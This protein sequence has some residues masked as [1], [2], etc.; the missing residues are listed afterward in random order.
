[1][2]LVN[3]TFLS[4][5]I[6]DHT[7]SVSSV[8]MKMW[9]Q[10]CI[11]STFSWPTGRMSLIP[12]HKVCVVDLRHVKEP[13][14]AWLRCFVSHMSQPLFLTY[15]SPASVPDGS[16]CWIR[17]IWMHV[18]GLTA[19]HLLLICPNLGYGTIL[20]VAFTHQDC[21]ASSLVWFGFLVYL[22]LYI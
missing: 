11:S 18:L 21:S 7:A 5:C 19:S 12:F 10:P 15:D 9:V 8:V 22:Y 6:T 20:T 4:W 16:V 17:M 1:M 3:I 2:K 13:Y 14:R